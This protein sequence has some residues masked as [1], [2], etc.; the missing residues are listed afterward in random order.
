M[1]LHCYK[2]TGDAKLVNKTGKL[3][4]LG[5]H[6]CSAYE[7]V[8][9]THCKVIIAA[10]DANKDINYVSLDVFGRTKYYFVESKEADTGGRCTLNLKTDVLNTYKSEIYELEPIVSRTVYTKGMNSF[11]GDARPLQGY[12]VTT[13]YSATPEAVTFQYGRGDQYT[14]ENWNGMNYILLIAGCG[15][16]QS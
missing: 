4:D 6:N 15:L 5:S 16:T 1:T 12:N 9:D 11:I 2:F 13:E 7:P 14:N 8:D 10:A 3:Q